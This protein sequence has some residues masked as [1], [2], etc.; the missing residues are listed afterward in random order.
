MDAGLIESTGGKTY[1]VTKG[2]QIG[3]KYEKEE[4]VMKK[5]IWFRMP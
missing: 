4:K 5:M 2:K 1:T 3:G